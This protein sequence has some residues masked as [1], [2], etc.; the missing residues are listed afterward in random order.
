MKSMFRPLVVLFAV[1]TAV[2]GLVYPAVMTAFG[3]VAFPSQAGGS[4]I[5]QNGRTVGSALIGQPFDAPRYFWGRLSATSP[6]PYNAQGSSA[7]NLGPTNPALA[8]Q[9]KGRLDALKAAGTDMSQPVP[10]DLVTASGSGLDPEIS[11]AAAAYQ[12]ERVARARGL[13]ADAVRQ[14]VDAN[15]KG[16]QFGLL[17]EPR[18][19]VLA[20]NLALDSTKSAH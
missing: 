11:P 19:N 7:S 1:L 9:V 8:D 17:G 2:T 16:R 4:L 13:P 12:V 14:L 6:M 18:V 10:V 15:T 20:L 5:E 3:S